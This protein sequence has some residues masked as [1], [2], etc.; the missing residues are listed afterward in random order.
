[1]GSGG[2]NGDVGFEAMMRDR[3]RGQRTVSGAGR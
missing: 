2:P 1:M 3:E